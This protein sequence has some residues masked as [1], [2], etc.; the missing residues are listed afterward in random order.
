MSTLRQ[1]S[2]LIL[3][4]IFILLASCSPNT[5]TQSTP[6]PTPD[7]DLN[8]PVTPPFL[9]TIEPSLSPNPDDD[10]SDEAALAAFE[11]S[12]LAADITLGEELDPDSPGNSVS[13]DPSSLLWLDPYRILLAKGTDGGEY[14]IR[15][16]TEEEVLAMVN[17]LSSFLLDVR[18]ACVGNDYITK[19]MS[20]LAKG[21]TDFL[22]EGFVSGSS[23]DDGRWFGVN[24]PSESRFT[25]GD[26]YQRWFPD[27]H[28]LTVTITAWDNYHY[29]YH[30]G[31]D[32]Y[33]DCNAY[34]YTDTGKL[35][36]RTD[37]SPYTRVFDMSIFDCTVNE[38][39]ERIDA[40][41]ERVSIISCRLPGEEWPSVSNSEYSLWIPSFHSDTPVEDTTEWLYGLVTEG[42]YLPEGADKEHLT[43]QYV[44]ATDA[45]DSI[46]YLEYTGDPLL[47]ILF[48]VD[49]ERE[50]VHGV[51]SAAT[52][53]AIDYGDG[54]TAPNK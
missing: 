15:T 7:S 2:A 25:E 53:A 28:R 10:T 37:Y 26:L 35:E 50:N 33:E 8:V 51:Y 45:M 12:I 16:R 14:I 31:P 11:K 54:W 41:I 48:F 24:N 46:L 18:A 49:T 17:N 36:L 38:L 22:P 20:A 39:L 19:T 30:P 1:I 6:S 3:A 44:G 34:I 13:L 40:S 29:L 21:D 23:D 42:G 5:S 52:L 27:A 43:Y 32:G 4:L 47:K 9:D